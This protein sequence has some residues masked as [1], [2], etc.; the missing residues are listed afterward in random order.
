VVPFPAPADQTV[1]VPEG[2]RHPLAPLP[3]PAPP[4]LLPVISA[5]ADMS[6]GLERVLRPVAERAQDGDR[7]ARDALY[8]AFEP[9]LHRIEQRFA[10]VAL[11]RPTALWDRG[12]LANE[13]YLVFVGLIASWNRERP[14]GRYVL[15]AYRWRLGD[16][17]YRGIGR[18]SAPGRWVVGVRDHRL[19]AISE[20]QREVEAASL[21]ETLVATFEAPF[22]TVLRL[23]VVEGY[24]LVDVA[25]MT[26]V[27]RRT[28]NR[29]W[30]RIRRRLRAAEARCAR[31]G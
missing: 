21:V 12:D 15:S 16:V 31:P 18:S 4:L 24:S 20:A 22:D 27:S 29:Y 5:V 25:R 26:G 1:T 30:A 6:D 2:F 10:R 11:D 9:K 14:F 8:H 28:V 17:I 23:H 19:E 13:G 3:S 7:A